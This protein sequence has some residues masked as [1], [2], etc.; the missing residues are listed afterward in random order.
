MDSTSGRF[1]IGTTLVGLT[2]TVSRKPG[3]S[4]NQ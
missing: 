2:R 4:G 3:G 1:M